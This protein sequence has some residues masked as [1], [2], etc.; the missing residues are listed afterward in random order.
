MKEITEIFA[1]V[2]QNED[3]EG[4]MAA[5]LPIDGRMMMTPLVF[6]HERLLEKMLPLAKE[7]ST[8]SGK[9]FRILKFTSREDITEQV[10]E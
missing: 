3:E 8:I 6:A 1:F 10:M 9:P 7:I 5:S 2:A 4:I